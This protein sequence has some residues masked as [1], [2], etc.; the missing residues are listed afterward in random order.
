[1]PLLLASLKQNAH[2]SLTDGTEF[3]ALRNIPKYCLGRNNS[4]QAHWYLRGYF[5]EIG[6]ENW[7]HK[8]SCGKKEESSYGFP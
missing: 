6:E 4:F 7:K 5:C 3:A 1:M 8:D 2:N